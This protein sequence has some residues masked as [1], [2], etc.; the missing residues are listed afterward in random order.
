MIA[1]S[2][3]HCPW[4]DGFAANEALSPGVPSD[5]SWTPPAAVGDATGATLSAL[6]GCPPTLL[7]AATI[8]D[9]G[10]IQTDSKRT[11]C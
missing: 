6:D 1:T 10:T 7:P 3:S 2:W 4:L 9:V 8:V 5:G 11:S